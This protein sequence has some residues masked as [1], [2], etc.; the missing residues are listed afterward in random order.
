MTR[1]ACESDFLTPEQIRNAH[2]LCQ[3]KLPLPLSTVKHLL[4]AFHLSFIFLAITSNFSSLSAKPVDSNPMIFA[5]KRSE[6]LINASIRMAQDKKSSIETRRKEFCKYGLMAQKWR[7]VAIMEQRNI[8]DATKLIYK[9]SG[10]TENEALAAVKE[11]LLGLREAIN[12]NNE[13][14]RTYAGCSKAP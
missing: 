1:R 14:E 9:L 8:V 2:T 4:Q 11:D 7:D 12:T 10:M 3:I 6:E 5:H 13:Y